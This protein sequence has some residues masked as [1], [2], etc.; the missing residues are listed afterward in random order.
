MRNDYAAIETAVSGRGTSTLRSA[1]LVWAFSGRLDQPADA[2][3]VL[4]IAH[5]LARHHD[6]Q[7]SAEDLSRDH[8]SDDSVVAE[9]KRCIDA[10]NL[11][12]AELVDRIDRWAEDR[13]P[14]NEPAALHTETLGQLIDR[15]AVAWVRS[16]KLSEAS[17]D[18]LEKRGDARSAL[19]QLAQL[20]DA[21]DDLMRDLYA[22]RRRLPVWR[23]LKRYGTSR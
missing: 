6:V 5:E 16:R 19:T 18:D 12:R 14:G 17:G 23:S 4:A 8:A 2:D 3:P 22:G 11:V 21:Y 10:M 15:L 7:W 9:A 13:L 1:D 20:C